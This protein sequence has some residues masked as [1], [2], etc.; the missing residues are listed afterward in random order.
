MRPDWE[1][2]GIQLYCADCM[3]VLPHLSGV[4]AVITDPPYSSGGAFRSDRARSTGK[5]YLGSHNSG[6]KIEVDFSGDSRDGRGW[7]FWATMW[8][9]KAHDAC[10]PS[11]LAMMFTDW[12]QLPTATDVMQAAGWIWRGVAVWDKGTARPMSGR[13]SHQAEFVVWGSCGSLGWDFTKPCVN[14]VLKFDAPK[15]FHQTEKPTALIEEMLSLTPADGLILDPFMGSGTT[16][17]ACVK[18]GRK[19]IGIEKE[20]RYFDIAVKRI[21]RALSEE[22][23]SLFPVSKEIQRELI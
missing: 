10:N 20:S 21:E 12:R 7:C 8:L 3:D 15:E 13:F 6:P 1:R 14:G 16:G 5:K 17:V 4:D 19:F 23:S 18:L 11:S 9:L 22:R 2:D